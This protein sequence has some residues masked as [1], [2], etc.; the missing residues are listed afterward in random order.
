MKTAV[1]EELDGYNGADRINVASHSRSGQSDNGSKQWLPHRQR[2]HLI[3]WVVYCS[4]NW[5]HGILAPFAA[6][7]DRKRAS[8]IIIITERGDHQDERQ[9]RLCRRAVVVNAVNCQISQ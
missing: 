9:C 2:R 6:R 4:Y 8:G 5:L 7:S 3:R 1:K